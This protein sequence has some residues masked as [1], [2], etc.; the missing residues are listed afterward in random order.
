MLIIL[1]VRHSAV[2]SVQEMLNLLG[3]GTRDAAGRFKPLL[4]DGVFGPDSESTIINFQRSEGLLGDGVVGPN[5][6]RALEKAFVSRRPQPSTID[7]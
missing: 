1:G 7:M 4:V 6:L 3:F 2:K 5:T